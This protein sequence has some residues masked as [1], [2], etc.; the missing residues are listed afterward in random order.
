MAQDLCTYE[1]VQRVLGTA[2]GSQI[3]AERLLE[4][5][6]DDEEGVGL[7]AEASRA[8]EAQIGREVDVNTA[9]I[10]VSGDG[11]NF[12]LLPRAY[13]PVISVTSVTYSGYDSNVDVEVEDA[14]AGVLRLASATLS[15]HRDRLSLPRFPVGVNN[16]TVTLTYGWTSVPDDIRAAVA[17]M[18]AI[19]LLMLDQDEQDGGVTSRRLGDRSVSYGG[20]GRHM[21]RVRALQRYV[22]QVLR[23][24]GAEVSV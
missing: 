21:L 18:V 11:T 8:F 13:T 6:D 5:V 12:L 4:L 22:N 7:I 3:D 24:Y 20:A 14:E 15:S 9:T 19:E 1:D 17:R 10:T 16:I 2:L 23:R